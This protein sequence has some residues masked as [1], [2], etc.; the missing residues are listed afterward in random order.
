M[1]YGKAQTVLVA[2]GMVG[3]VITLAVGNV[4]F[5]S[6]EPSL[7]IQ[8]MMPLSIFLTGS[9]LYNVRCRL[10]LLYGCVEVVVGVTIAWYLANVAVGKVSKEG[11]T[12]FAAMT[13]LYVI[14]R[15]YDNVY[16]SLKSATAIRGWNR[17]FS[18]QDTERK[19]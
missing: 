1:F 9:V 6:K 4:A 3:F 8:L 10:P 13:A 11:L 14:V 5:S 15:G 19:L 12:V 17:V 2:M 16:R 7:F 18:D